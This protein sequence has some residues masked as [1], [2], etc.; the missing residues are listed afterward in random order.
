M[1]GMETRLL[2]DENL[3]LVI[4][5]STVVF[6]CI[7]ELQSLRTMAVVFLSGISLLWLPLK[8]C[9]VVVGLDLCPEKVFSLLKSL[10][11]Q[12]PILRVLLY[13]TCLRSFRWTTRHFTLTVRE[14]SV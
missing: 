9:D 14:L 10:I 8:G 6:W 2:P 12:R 7:V 4:L 5:F 3:H 1:P 11:E 13:M